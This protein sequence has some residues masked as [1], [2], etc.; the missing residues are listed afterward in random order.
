MLTIERPRGSQYAEVTDLSCFHSARRVAVP[1]LDALNSS[2][3]PIPSSRTPFWA[4]PDRGEPKL[5]FK[6]SDNMTHWEFLQLSHVPDPARGKTTVRG[7]FEKREGSRGSLERSIVRR[8]EDESR[9]RWVYA[10][11]S[12]LLVRNLISSPFRSVLT[13]V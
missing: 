5:S 7:C 3:P 13:Q 2:T 10:Y 12:D 1:P 11:T 6:A 9:V 8:C 4:C